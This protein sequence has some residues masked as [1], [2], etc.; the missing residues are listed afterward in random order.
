MKKITVADAV[1]AYR[2]MNSKEFNLSKVEGREKFAVI[3][4]IGKLKK[5]A[6]DY[7]DFLSEAAKRLKPAG[8]DAVAAKIQ[9][10]E[11]LTPGEEAMARTYNDE[12]SECLQPE[13]NS[14]KEVD[15]DPVPED[16]LAKMFD[17]N[18]NLP[19]GTMAMLTDALGENP[20]DD[21]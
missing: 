9:A 1:T 14:V 10:G 15:F 21:E 17:S 8:Y 4:A 20:T 2:V 16:A 3:R 6:S 18:P 7:D 19:L 13:F 11:K 12:L 5:V